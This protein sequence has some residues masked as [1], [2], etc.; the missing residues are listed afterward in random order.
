[1]DT[2]RVLIRTWPAD[3][4]GIGRS[5]NSTL[6]GVFTIAIGYAFFIASL[7]NFG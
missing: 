1:M 3:N 7:T 5:S 4:S 2:A 6:P